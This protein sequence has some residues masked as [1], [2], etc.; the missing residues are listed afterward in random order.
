MSQLDLTH[1]ACCDPLRAECL[2][3]GFDL[4]QPARV[5]WYNDAV[6]P[7]YRL[8][9]LGS[10]DSLALVIG[11]TRALWPRFLEAVA[12]DPDLRAARDPLDA[13]TVRVISRAAATLPHPYEVRF[14]HE[15]PPR[16][17]AMQ[18]LAHVSGLAY[19]SPSFMCVHPVFGPWIALRAVVVV[20]VP[21]PDSPAPTWDAPCACAGHCEDRFRQACE[22]VARREERGRA[23]RDD[24]RAWLAVRDACPVGRAHRYSDEQIAYHY[25]KDRSILA[26]TGRPSRQT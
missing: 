13:Y 10:P 2:A 16:R 14:S 11:N 12:A 6:D 4:F 1:P 21:G 26:A 3:A 9:A 15:P 18:R 20:P 25:T 23:A 5:G 8:P 24:W 7:A 17:V 19:L 22:L